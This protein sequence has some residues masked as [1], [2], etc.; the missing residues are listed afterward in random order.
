MRKTIIILGAA[1][2]AAA[3][4]GAQAACYS[5]GVRVGVVQKLSKKGYMNK[6]WEG[7]L[8]QDGMRVK[9]SGHGAASTDVW[10]FSVLDEGVAKKAD[11]AVFNGDG[12]ALRYCQLNTLESMGK[13]DS[14]YLVTEIRERK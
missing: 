7:E 14:S 12:V 8:V 11:E 6:S 9:A 4:I 10:R 13:I 1:L 2:L 5:E 3:S